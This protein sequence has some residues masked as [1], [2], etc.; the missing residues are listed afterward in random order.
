MLVEGATKNTTTHSGARNFAMVP[1]S[2]ELIA[3][4]DGGIYRLR[5]NKWQAMFGPGS[6]LVISEVNFVSLNPLNGQ[7]FG[8]TQGNGS[9]FVVD[10]KKSAIDISSGN[11]IQGIYLVLILSALV[12]MLSLQQVMAR[13]YL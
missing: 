1:Q 8:G 9:P 6:G 12:L 5:N 3:L 11:V 10:K 7:P 4:N 13:Q 2:E